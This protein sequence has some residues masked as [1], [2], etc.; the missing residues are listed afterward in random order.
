MLYFNEDETINIQRRN[1]LLDHLLARHGESPF[2]ID[3]LVYGT[4]YSGNFLKDRVIL[5]SMYL[6]NLAILSYNRTKAYNSIGAQMLSDFIVPITPIFVNQLKASSATEL[7]KD[8]QS[9]VN[10]Q[11]TQIQRV[12]ANAES[13]AIITLYDILTKSYKKDGIFDTNRIDEEE[14]I[15]QTDLLNFTTISLKLSMLLTL[16]PFNYTKLNSD[17]LRKLYR[18]SSLRSESFHKINEIQLEK[19]SLVYVD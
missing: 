18:I 3:T 15:T 11:D 14:K 5:K 8:L 6:Q 7:L 17:K 16:K 13:R 9:S 10:P 2:I 4:V 19:I 1:D 12:N